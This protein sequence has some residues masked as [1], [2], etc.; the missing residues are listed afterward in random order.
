MCDLGSVW[1]NAAGA[2]GAQR[3]AAA[4]PTRHHPHVAA[5]VAEGALLPWTMGDDLRVEWD[6]RLSS[7]PVVETS[8]HFRMWILVCEWGGLLHGLGHAP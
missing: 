4:R 5:W 2:L 1:Q 6:P 3:G 8:S 7:V